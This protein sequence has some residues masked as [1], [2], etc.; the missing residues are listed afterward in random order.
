MTKLAKLSDGRPTHLTERYQLAENLR[1]TRLLTGPLTAHALLIYLAAAL[2]YC[3]VGSAGGRI[4]DYHSIEYYAVFNELTHFISV[5]IS[6]AF[7]ASLLINLHRQV[8]DF[9]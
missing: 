9:L 8:C 7:L 5:L 1:I 4:T 3:V 2:L 6:P